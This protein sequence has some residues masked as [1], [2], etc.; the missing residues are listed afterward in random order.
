MVTLDGTLVSASVEQLMCGQDGTCLLS[1]GIH[2]GGMTGFMIFALGRAIN[3][4]PLERHPC[5]IIAWQTSLHSPPRMLV[6]T[7]HI[8][9]NQADML[10]ESDMAHRFF[11]GLER[12]LIESNDIQRAV[13]L[14]DDN[15]VLN[16]AVHLSKGTTGEVT[17]LEVLITSEP[18][19][20]TLMADMAAAKTAASIVN[21]DTDMATSAVSTSSV[22]ESDS[23][24]K[25]NDDNMATDS[26]THAW[27]AGSAL[28]PS[29]SPNHT[30]D[31]KD[32]DNTSLNS[33]IAESTAVPTPTATP[34][35]QSDTVQEICSP[36][37]LPLATTP[38]EG[39]VT[40]T[41]LTLMVANV[42]TDIDFN[43]LPL[44]HLMWLD[45]V[46]LIQLLNRENK[47]LLYYKRWS[48]ILHLINQPF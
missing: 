27:L 3:G 44:I 30:L 20:S 22:S 23:E 28:T 2:S 7:M 24:E 29:A 36:L 11:N 26:V 48:I 38:T 32:D 21:N 33:T 37:M 45:R 12:Q 8:L 13:K 19:S 17:G 14:G 40:E 41:Q 25:N 10:V 39:S 1:P 46:Y 34:G 16:L 6:H 15:D 42:G 4:M 43:S 31:H 18:V 5:L 35:L 9:P 47:Q